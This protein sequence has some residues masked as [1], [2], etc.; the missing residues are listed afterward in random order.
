VLAKDKP[1]SRESLDRCFEGDFCECLEAAPQS[2]AKLVCSFRPQELAANAYKPY[3]QFGPAIPETARDWEVPG[4]RYLD[5]IEELAKLAE[6]ELDMKS[7]ASS[8]RSRQVQRVG[9]LGDLLARWLKL[10]LWCERR[11]CRRSTDMDLPDLIDRH[12]SEMPL[13]ALM[14]RAVCQVCWARY[15]EVGCQTVPDNLP[16][17]GACGGGQAERPSPGQDWPR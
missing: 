10:R 9:T 17:V 11:N 3:E 12:G 13:Q 1:A 6:Q 4:V 5:A 2:V 7:S 16:A 8:S 15:R 14:E